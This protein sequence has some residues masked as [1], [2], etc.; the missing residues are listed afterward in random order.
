MPDSDESTAAQVDPAAPAAS[1]RPQPHV[2]A[3]GWFSA[4]M[5]PA[6]GARVEMR[7][8]ADGGMDLRSSEYPDVVLHY[9]RSE[10]EAWLDGANKHEF[11]HLAED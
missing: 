9:T 2:S 5:A 6:E 4:S 3:D 1:D 7:P 10:W 8:R 11:D